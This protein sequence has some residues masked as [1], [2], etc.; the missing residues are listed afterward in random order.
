MEAVPEELFVFGVVAGVHGLRG[1]LKV[2][3]ATAGSMVLAEASR[4]VLR[5]PDGTT[6]SYTTQK[7]APHKGNL[8]VRLKGLDHIDKVQGL[9]GCEVL[10]PL[11]ELPDTDEDEFYWHELEGLTVVDRTR[12]ELG[13]LDEMFTTAAHDIYVVNG[14]Y[15]EVL[16]PAV[17]A[18]LEE[19]D[20]EG[21]R[22]MV[23]LP[24]G[25]IPESDEV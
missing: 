5:H 9:M 1:D 3:P 4:V 23:D 25:L 10:M 14:P 21:R 15:G 13:T 7:V 8:L 24:E 19:I 22:M 20:L 2:R 17:E 6:S 18:F 11:D 16:I 12:G